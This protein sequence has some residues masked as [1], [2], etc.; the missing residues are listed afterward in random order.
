MWADVG[1]NPFNMIIFVAG[2]IAGLAVL[3]GALRIPVRAFRRIGH[4]IDDLQGQ[5]A[6]PGVPAQPGVMV[7]LQQLEEHTRQLKPNGGTHLAD[8]IS[9]IEAR[10]AVIESRINAISDQLFEREQR[11][12]QL[13]TLR[14]EKTEE[15]HAFERRLAAVETLL[16]RPVR[17]RRITGDPQDR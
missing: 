6:R 5:P 7:R 8:K 16:S 4:L 17:R 10:G 14:A 12:G 2:V 11:I 13:E 3:V 9:V 15:H 1:N